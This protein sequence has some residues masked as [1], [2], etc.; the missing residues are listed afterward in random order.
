MFLSQRARWR[1]EADFGKIGRGSAQA[2][3]QASHP[4]L[5]GATFDRRPFRFPSPTAE[6]PANRPRVARQ[7]GRFGIGWGVGSVKAQKAVLEEPVGTPSA[8]F[9]R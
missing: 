4:S 6:T 9:L 5:S 7:D 1:G 8:V 2:A 3:A